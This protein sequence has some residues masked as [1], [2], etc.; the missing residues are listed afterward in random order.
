MATN[1]SVDIRMT[2]TYPVSAGYVTV[3]VSSTRL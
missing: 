3:L 1:S 2:S